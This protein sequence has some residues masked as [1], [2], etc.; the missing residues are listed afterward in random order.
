MRVL[1]VLLLLFLLLLLPPLLPLQLVLLQTTMRRGRCATWSAQRT[2]NIVARGRLAATACCHRIHTPRDYCTVQLSR[3]P[4]DR[5]TVQ[6]SRGAADPRFKQVPAIIALC[7]FR[8]DL[9]EDGPLRHRLRSPMA[10][11][12][13]DWPRAAC[14]RRTMGNDRQWTTTTTAITTNRTTTATVTTTT[15]TTNTCTT[16]TTSAAAD[17]DI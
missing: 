7:N 2:N 12:D 17:D 9:H 13:E 8:G 15:M 16:V 10:N 3:P 1:L 4:R 5:G 6:L 11:L 14:L